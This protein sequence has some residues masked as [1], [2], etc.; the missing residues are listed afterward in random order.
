M[1]PNAMAASGTLNETMR[2]SI[3]PA[4]NATATHTRKPTAMTTA[5]RLTAFGR[6]PSLR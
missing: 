1:P 4:A 2:V 5:K 3:V 6:R